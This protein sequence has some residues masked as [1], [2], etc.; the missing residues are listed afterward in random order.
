[1]GCLSI[2][3]FEGTRHFLLSHCSR[4]VQDHGRKNTQ[5]L[6][7]GLRSSQWQNLALVHHRE[8]SQQPLL[9]QISMSTT[10]VQELPRWLSGGSCRSNVAACF[11]ACAH[12]CTHCPRR[13]IAYS[14]RLRPV[15]G[16][17]SSRDPSL[18]SS[19]AFVGF[20]KNGA[21]AV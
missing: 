9:C 14:Y 2:W 5:K 3:W 21:L 12:A 17:A 19:A 4:I 15:Q 13:N 11:D 16:K 8:H 1:M 10:N 7:E 18:V 6:R 20:N